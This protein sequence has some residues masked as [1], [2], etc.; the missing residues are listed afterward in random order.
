MLR[1]PATRRQ[2][3]FWSF[4]STTVSPVLRKVPS[5][6]KAVSLGNLDPSPSGSWRLLTSQLLPLVFPVHPFLHPLLMP[7][8]QTPPSTSNPPPQPGTGTSMG[9][10]RILHNSQWNWSSSQS[11]P[12]A[13]D[14]QPTGKGAARGMH[15]LLGALGNF[16]WDA[17][18]QIL[19]PLKRRGWQL[20]L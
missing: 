6:K 8:S 1:L 10:S 11:G 18:I 17:G 20:P 13:W 12:L 7:G 2:D 15:V 3:F 14:T 9:G 16:S 4:L 19:F 5:A